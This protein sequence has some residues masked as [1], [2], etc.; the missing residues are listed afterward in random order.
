ME[1][2]AAYAPLSPAPGTTTLKERAW[3]LISSDPA[4]AA[5]NMAIDEAIMARHGQGFVPPTLRFYSWEPPAVS[6]GYFQ[7]L[8]G[9]VDLD[10]CRRLG[11]GWVR[12][13]TGG[14]A[15]LHHREVTYSIVIRE[16][17]LPGNVI[18]TYRVISQGLL[19]GLRTLGA[20]AFLADPS[21]QSIEEKMQSLG[22][23][24]CFDSPSFYELVV[25]GKKVV[26]SAQT[27]KDGVIL[28][29][30]SIL[31]DL[32][33]GLLFEVLRTPP[34]VQERIQRAFERKASS[35]GRELGRSLAWS[36]VQAAVAAGFTSA[37]NLRLTPGDLTAPEWDLAGDLLKGKYSQDHW[38]YRK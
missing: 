5:A 23:G 27:R 8:S 17:L 25:G 22:S 20:D 9:E 4:D 38:N 33:S 14:R 10:A 32:D 36:E 35:L 37:L 13:P 11:I 16:E 19:A 31:L 2:A 24:A 12:R 1:L 28:Q 26:G 6:I 29:H 7:S 15:V 18:E 3:R 34:G 30:G 21:G